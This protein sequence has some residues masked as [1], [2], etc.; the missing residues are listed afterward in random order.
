MK[1]NNFIKG[2]DYLIRSKISNF[3]NPTCRKWSYDKLHMKYKNVVINKGDDNYFMTREQIQNIGLANVDGGEPEYLEEGVW[4]T[5]SVKLN[6]FAI[7]T[8]FL[9][10]AILKA[11]M[12]LQY[13]HNHYL[14]LDIDYIKWFTIKLYDMY[15]SLLPSKK[16]N[17]MSC[18]QN[19]FCNHDENG[20]RLDILNEIVGFTENDRNRLLEKFKE[21]EAKF[22]DT[23]TTISINGIEYDQ[24]FIASIL[25]MAADYYKVMILAD[26]DEDFF[27]LEDQF[28][29]ESAC[30]LYC[31]S[32]NLKGEP[33]KNAYQ[34][35]YEHVDSNITPTSMDE[36][37]EACLYMVIR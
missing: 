37:K 13:L 17:D 12:L 36:I 15:Q 6:D 28:H 20:V 1:E 8:E 35:T 16:A 4:I 3:H 34:K 32:F 27:S 24:G 11:I 14:F 33:V 22:F 30:L 2:R 21:I 9:R 26:F 31:I 18:F 19:Y 25:S 7:S 29:L 5:E 10:E 23:K